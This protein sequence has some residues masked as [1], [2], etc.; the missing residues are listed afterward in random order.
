MR[1]A[2]QKRFGASSEKSKY[3]QYNLFNEAEATANQ[4]IAEPELTEVQNHYRR[5]TKKSKDRLPENLPVEVV[6]HFLP[7]DE[8]ACPECGSNL[9]IMG[10][11]VR[12]ELKLIPA[13]AIIVEHIDYVYACR[14]CETNACGVPIIKAPMDQPVIKGSFAS[15]EAVAHI[16]TQKFVNGMPLYRQEQEFNRMGIGLSRQTMSNWVVK[17]AEDWLE[18][19]YNTLHQMLNEQKILHADE[20]VLQVLHEPGKAPKSKSYMWL[21]RTSRDSGIPIVLF[22][23]QPNR[24]KKTPL[25]IFKRVQWLPSYGR[26]CRIP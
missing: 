22:E 6:E 19:I 13:K 24:K 3:D 26:L 25:G 21:Y 12:R 23:Y 9:H 17:C 1:L 5:K 7:E 15:P 8:Q 16:M 11:E 20:T 18:P 14:N 10:K 4:K 2:R